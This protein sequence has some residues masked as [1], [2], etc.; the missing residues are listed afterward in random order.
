MIEKG[1]WLE[2]INDFNGIKNREKKSKAETRWIMLKTWMT[3]S[4]A[5]GLSSNITIRVCF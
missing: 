4:L 1:K 5:S 3:F 2:I